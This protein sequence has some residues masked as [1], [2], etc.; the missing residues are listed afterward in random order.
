MRKK[1]TAKTIEH[2]PIP[3]IGRVD[4]WDE[5]ITG[6][7]IRVAATG[8]KSWFA[9][10]R[11]N[12]KLIRHTIGTYPI[13]ELAIARDEARKV[14]SAMQLGKYYETLKPTPP[15]KERTLGETIIEFIEKHAKPN[16]RSWKSTKYSL[17]YF[18]KL[19]EKPLSEITRL[20][21]VE[22]LDDIVGLGRGSA[23]N[24][25]LAAIRKLFS[26]ALDR[27]LVD[28][29]PAA[30]L[31]L[32]AKE[33]S[34]DRV[35]SDEEIAKFWNSIDNLYPV[36]RPFYKM[37]LLTGQR[38]TEVATM[39]WADLDFKRMVWTIPSAKAKNGR[40][41]EVPLTDMM[42]KLLQSIPRFIYAEYVFTTTGKTPISGFSKCTARIQKSMDV[43]DWRI[44]DLR[45]TC[46]SGLARLS[47]APHIIEKILNHSSGQ[48]SGVAAIYNRYGYE[49]EKREA[50]E[51]WSNHVKGIIRGSKRAL[52]QAISEETMVS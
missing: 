19:G 50:L 28:R 13:M 52:A 40:V 39:K 31:K 3:S 32:P 49:A 42:V 20:E 4:I 11:E 26:W 14:L 37:L 45:R 29:H 6:F 18:E 24:R 16:N 30:G 2:L 36:F 33:I 47:V 35:L 9:I 43:E 48:I 34:R 46:A 41:S 51:K 5:L 7:G 22:V 27:G 44:H 15:P 8:R 38:R 12:G 21:I 25:A 23:A 10:G 1:F 17:R